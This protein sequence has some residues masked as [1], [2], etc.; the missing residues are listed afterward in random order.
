VDS[1]DWPLR[2]KGSKL[3]DWAVR[4]VVTCTIKH[5]SFLTHLVS[6]LCS[7]GYDARS[8]YVSGS[9]VVMFRFKKC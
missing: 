2:L 6:M 7:V 8:C 9:E 5:A 1:D 3:Y 4:V